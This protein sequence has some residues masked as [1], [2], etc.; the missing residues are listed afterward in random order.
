[1]PLS[2]AAAEPAVAAAH[3]PVEQ[4]G[5]G[6]RRGSLLVTRARV[7]RSLQELLE[8]QEENEPTATNL[9]WASPLR[10]LPYPHPLLRAPNLAVG[11]FDDTLRRLAEEMFEVMYDDDGVGLAAPQVGVNVRLMVFNESG[12]KG[13]GEE[14]VLVNPRVLS[15]NSAES[16]FEEGCLSFPSIY[17]D[18]TRP[19][20]V[21]VRAQDLTG[22][23][24]TFALSGFPARIFQ[25]EY[26]HLQ[27]S[28][29][30]DRMDAEVL[31]SVRPDLQRM[32]D[33]YLRQ[34][35]DQE[36]AIEALR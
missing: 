11:A 16:L 26:D 6:R 4:R 21:K 14:L 10:V 22:K 9:E 1:M 27:G 19:T 29:F 20:R 18:V 13:K 7:N 3:S 34:Y 2:H 5:R 23:R 36:Q 12:E 25:H 35:P 32:R 31:E 24:F 17:G 28:L 33:Q 8:Q 15:T 30:I